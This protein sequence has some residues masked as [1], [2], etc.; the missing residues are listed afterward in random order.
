MRHVILL[1]AAAS[2]ARGDLTGVTPGAANVPYAKSGSFYGPP[3]EAVEFQLAGTGTVTFN[4]N[5][6]FTAWTNKTGNTAT[7]PT[8]M[9]VYVGWQNNCT[10]RFTGSATSID[11]P[12]T[13]VA[14]EDRQKIIAVDAAGTLL[15]ALGFC[16]APNSIARWPYICG[17]QGGQKRPGGDL[18]LLARGATMV[19]AT[20]GATVRSLGPGTRSYVNTHQFSADNQ[21]LVST[22]SLGEG[23]KTH[24][25]K[26]T[27]ADASQDFTNIS[28]S[29]GGF[30]CSQDNSNAVWMHPT[31]ATKGVCID[32][33][34]A[35]TFTA[36][37]PPTA[38]LIEATHTHTGPGTWGWG[39]GYPS[40]EGWFAHYDAAPNQRVCVTNIY[41]AGD[42][43]TCADMPYDAGTADAATD[44]ITLLGGTIPHRFVASNDSNR[45]VFLTT[46][47]TMP[48]GLSANTFYRVESVTTYGLTLKTQG[49]VHV[50][51]TSNGTGLRIHYKPR[52]ISIGLKASRTDGKHYIVVTSD[53]PN[54]ANFYAFDS[55]NRTLA[56]SGQNLPQVY[57]P[58]ATAANAYWGNDPLG[59]CLSDCITA[60]HFGMAY[61][62]GEPWNISTGNG[63]VLTPSYAEPT[64]LVRMAQYKHGGIY[65]GDLN[66]PY[67]MNLVA[68]TG[69]YPSSL[70]PAIGGTQDLNS[71]GSK[72]AWPIASCSATGSAITF[73][74]RAG[75]NFDGAG[76]PNFVDGVSQIQIDGVEGLSSP[77]DGLRTT[78]TGHTS[79]TFTISDARTGSCTANKG[80]VT[81]DTYQQ[82]INGTSFDATPSGLLVAL[83]DRGQV[84]NVAKT[85]SVS[86]GSVSGW[87]SQGS[88]DGITAGSPGYTDLNFPALAND[89]SMICWSTNMGHSEKKYLLCASTGLDLDENV[90]PHHFDRHG[91]GV[92]VHSI[93][94]GGATAIVK[95]T[96]AAFQCS[97]AVHTTRTFTDAAV[98]SA[99]A[100]TSGTSRNVSIANGTFTPGNQYYG[101]ARCGSAADKWRNYGI[102][103]FVA[104]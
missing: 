8:T 69:Y 97:I 58:N 83:A 91:R 21:Y 45:E 92:Y 86:Y 14:K 10:I 28:G 90:Q 30:I 27:A 38:T 59:R 80:S 88:W 51:I 1:L 48:G 63:R 74:L 82:D 2:V 23:Y 55:T 13:I 15:S 29:G 22:N 17:T 50:D 24:L 4:G 47:G 36:A 103:S 49:N 102:F 57:S 60:G 61:F 54:S 11:V 7:L 39:S 33:A 6:C 94:A 72:A 52:N 18:A 41:V 37:T 5:T 46:S 70:S 98:F 89:A 81:T 101:Y 68:Y 44:T 95:P 104:R 100:G 32:S 75:N 66:G 93:S 20:F 3:L 12:I 9:R 99:T 40:K 71:Q 87:N 53:N 65:T 19:D 31:I 84:F 26:I 96:D 77:I 34:G 73:T 64:H 78:V 42:S 16:S 56:L 79:T 62:A 76:G 85:F 43:D 35:K 67:L 25:R